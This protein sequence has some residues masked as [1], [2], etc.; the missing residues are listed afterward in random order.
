VNVLL[1]LAEMR[2]LVVIVKH[3]LTG[4]E[5]ELPVDTL[6]PEASKMQMLGNLALNI[7]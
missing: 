2:V 6:V 4:G 3:L 1:D 5:F 7:L